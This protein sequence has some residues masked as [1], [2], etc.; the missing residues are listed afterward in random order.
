MRHAILLSLATAAGLAT[1]LLNAQTNPIFGQA[2][3]TSLNSGTLD[4]PMATHAV[5]FEK[6]VTA[7][8][9]PWIRLEFD[10][11]SLPGTSY[12]EIVSQEGDVQHLDATALAN[13]QNHTAYF[14]GDSLFVRLVAGPHTRGNQ[15]SSRDLQVGIQVPP[16]PTVCGVDNRELSTDRRVAR[17]LSVGCSAWL[18]NT[19]NLMVSAGHCCGSSFR[20]AQFNVPPSSSTGALRHPPADDQYPVASS[21]IRTGSDWCVF[22]T[23][24]N[25]T[26]LHS[27]Q[28]QGSAFRL[29]LTKP[30]AGTVIRITGF[31]TVS[32]QPRTRNQAQTTSNGPLI[33]NG[34]TSFCYRTDTSGG[35]SG[36]PIINERTGQ[37]IGVHTN[38][39]CT[40][41]NTGCNSGTSI[42]RTAFTNALRTA[43]G[44][45]R[46]GAGGRLPPTSLFTFGQ[47]CPGSNGVAPSIA[48]S[49][50][51]N[52]KPL[53]VELNQ[54]LPN[55]VAL[56]L[57]GRDAHS[58][59]GQ[60]LPLSLASAGMPGCNL[61]LGPDASLAVGI[62][63]QGSASVSM[64]VPNLAALAGEPLTFQWLA[65]DSAANRAGFTASDAAHMQMGR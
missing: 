5:V 25:G 41:A 9:A 27:G 56:L 24:T 28:R 17:V 50:P 14:N 57:I 59:Q 39:G 30:A 34:G 1:P 37:A 11:V 38:G 19:R 16:P 63:A 18:I 47:G 44:A 36:S 20:T 23:L 46:D 22:E 2:V 21:S 48:V 60:L 61:Y 7:A 42:A 55:E 10:T 4:N 29:T 43:L 15:I 33:S 35:N 65:R 54:G 6:L 26:G 45:D 12:V 52:G 32:A 13:W 53:V 40:T 62:N 31:G 8:G 51:A 58:W 3:P 64:P 49:T